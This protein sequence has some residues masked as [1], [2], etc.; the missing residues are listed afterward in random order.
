VL[1]I[2][3]QWTRSLLY[4]CGTIGS[5]RHIKPV[6]RKRDSPFEPLT[7]DGEKPLYL[8]FA[9]LD[10]S[11]EACL[12]FARRGGLLRTESQTAAESLD[13]WRQEIRGMRGMIAAMSDESRHGQTIKI[14]SLDVFLR[15]GAADKRSVPLIL[16][17]NLISAMYLQLAS[18]DG[19]IGVCKHC[20]EWLERGATE[21][22]RSIAIFC[23]EKCK[24]RFH[25]LERAK[26]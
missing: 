22:R 4:E 17:G 1:D 19:S 8:R 5:R 24:N 6:G 11:E 13:D 2:N 9:A 10:E 23:S 7:I 16:P 21:S 14:T 12:D 15:M 18:S 25:Y 3:F 26:R 20:G